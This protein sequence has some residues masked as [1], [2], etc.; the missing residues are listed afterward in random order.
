M[1]ITGR[2]VTG[3]LLIVGSAPRP[4]QRSE[5]AAATA[6][7]GAR[8]AHLVDVSST[9]LPVTGSGDHQVVSRSAVGGLLTMSSVDG[10]WEHATRGRLL[11]AAGGGFVG[12]TSVGAFIAPAVDWDALTCRQR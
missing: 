7:G 9:R 10:F 1:P 12:G 5:K 3:R 2:K 11:L 4:R 8:S 6:G